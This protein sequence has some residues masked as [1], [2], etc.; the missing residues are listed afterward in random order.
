M[1]LERAG[2]LVSREEIQKEL[3]PNDTVVEFEHSI[4]AAIA[5][6]RKAFGDSAKGHRY[7]ETIAKRGYRLIAPVEWETDS[8]ESSFTSIVSS[9]N[10]SAAGAA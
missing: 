6:L 5:K 7:I 9:G 4:N 10:G 3:W 2:Q 8:G 1:L